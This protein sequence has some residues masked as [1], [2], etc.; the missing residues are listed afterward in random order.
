MW[1]REV[2]GVNK[3]VDKMIEVVFVFFLCIRVGI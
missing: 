3:F 2:V 1:Y